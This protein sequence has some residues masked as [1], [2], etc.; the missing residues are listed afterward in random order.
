MYACCLNILQCNTVLLLPGPST[1]HLLIES[2]FFCKDAVL[3]LLFDVVS[4]SGKEEQYAVSLSVA[5]SVNSSRRCL[6]ALV[7][8]WGFST[9]VVL[10]VNP[11]I[12]FRHE[13]SETHRGRGY[14]AKSGQQELKFSYAMALSWEKQYKTV[15]IGLIVWYHFVI[16]W[17]A[18]WNF[19]KY[20]IFLILRFSEDAK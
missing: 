15:L 4:L 9:C 20:S 13:K 12:S 3:F 2:W 11:N 18:F 6:S 14:V 8:Y 5:L 7:V 17:C 16:P 1:E 10:L 19:A